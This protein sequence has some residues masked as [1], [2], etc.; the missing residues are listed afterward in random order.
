MDR[1]TSYRS[2]HQDALPRSSIKGRP[3]CD[4]KICRHHPRIWLGTNRPRVIQK[5][6]L[7]S[8]V[9]QLSALAF[10]QEDEPISNAIFE[11]IGR[12][13]Q[14]SGRDHNLVPDYVALLGTVRA[15]QQ[16]TVAFRWSCLFESVEY[17]I[18]EALR[19]PKRNTP[20]RRKVATTTYSAGS[21]M[22]RWQSLQQR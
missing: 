18:E 21:A 11:A 2:D 15:C 19:P 17:R 8:M 7:F 10:S 12:I 4:I 20:K 16:Q 22:K 3:I 5:S 9:I 13:V 1:Q 6:A 14:E